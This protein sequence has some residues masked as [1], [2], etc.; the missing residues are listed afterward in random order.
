MRIKYQ[1]FKK[2]YL[3][4]LLILLLQKKNKKEKCR[5]TNTTCG[6]IKQN[7][8]EQ[9]PWSESNRRPILYERIVLP[10]NYMGIDFDKTTQIYYADKT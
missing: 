5:I 6:K 2:L 1:Y 7:L 9:S 4:F 8:Q 3:F 10:L